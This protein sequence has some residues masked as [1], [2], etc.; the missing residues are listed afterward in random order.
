M[1][2]DDFGIL[3]RELDLFVEFRLES[4][5][6]RLQTFLFIW[7]S[8]FSANYLAEIGVTFFEEHFVN[9]GLIFIRVTY[10]VG[11]TLLS[12]RGIDL[13]YYTKPFRGIFGRNSFDKLIVLIIFRL[14]WLNWREVWHSRMSDDI[15]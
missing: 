7:F 11:V 12:S 5:D 6:L 9:V 2:I 14:E 3:L 13:L 1:L 4:L 15:L 10:I 8:I